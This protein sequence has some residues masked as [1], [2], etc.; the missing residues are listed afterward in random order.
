MSDMPLPVILT[1]AYLAVNL[2]L[3]VPI[4]RD[5]A[6]GRTPPRELSAVSAALRWGPPLAGVIYLEF[7]AGDWLFVAFVVAF[8]GL[9]FWLLDGLLNYPAD[10]PRR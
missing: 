1:I 10:P 5:R 3:T 7:V 2:A 4:E 8:F 6:A 9:A